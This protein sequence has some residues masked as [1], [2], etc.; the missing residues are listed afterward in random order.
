MPAGITFSA[1][2]NDKAQAAA[3]MMS[4]NSQLSHSPPAS[5][6]CYTSGG[7]DGAGHSNL[8]LG[9]HGWDTISGCIGDAGAKRR[10]RPSP[11]DPPPQTQIMGTGDIPPVGGRT[12]NA[13]W[14]IDDHTWDPRPATRDGFVAWPPAGYV[15]YQVVF[16]RWS[17]SY[18]DADFSQATV[19][20]TRRPDRSHRAG[21]CR[22]GLWREHPRL[23]D[24]RHG[25]LGPLAAAVGRHALP[26]DHPAGAD[27]RHAAVFHLQGHRDGP[28]AGDAASCGME[29]TG[30]LEERR[31]VAAR[32]ARRGEAVADERRGADPETYVRTVA[33]TN[34]EIRGLGDQTGDG[35]AGI[36]WR[37]TIT[38]ADLSLADERSTP[39]SEMYVGTADPAYDIVGTGDFNGDAKSDILWRHTTNGEVWIWLMD[40]PRRSSQVYVGHAWTRRYV[41]KGVGDLDGDGKADI[42]WHHATSGEVWVWLMNGATAA[43]E[44]WVHG[45]GRALPESQ[46][47]PT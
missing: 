38:G 10:R 6:S 40:G 15:P 25:G 7:A 16:P 12:A 45:A 21:I 28:G 36:M 20:L 27:R 3:L 4:V 43:S 37:H 34:W 26:C 19:T 5:W 30:N 42:V 39:R 22:R 44:A 1:T 11:L 17:F 33:D 35:K 9:V 18:P 31:A 23:G 24:L 2:Y 47:S 29:F 41:V 14:V 8:F 46:A 32:D 13:L